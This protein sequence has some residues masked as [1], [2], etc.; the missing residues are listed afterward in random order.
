MIQSSSLALNSTFSLN[1]FERNFYFENH[2]D[3]FEDLGAISGIDS[4]IDARSFGVG[5]LDRDGDLDLVVK[6]LQRRLLQCFINEIETEAH[7]AFFSLTGSKSNR[8]AIGARIEIRHGRRSQMAQVRSASGFQ[9]QSSPEVF[10]GLGVDRQ[11]DHV[12]VYWP[13]G[14][15]QAFE[16]LA[17]GNVFHIHED[18]GVERSVPI[19]E[20][21][22]ATKLTSDSRAPVPKQTLF[23]KR[24]KAPPLDDV[25]T[26]GKAV[27]SD[28]LY[29][30]AVLA[31]FVQTWLP[32]FD[33]HLDLLEKIAKSHPDLEI[34]VFPHRG[35]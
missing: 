10:F 21:K 35:R 15:Q 9:S 11:I 26:N 22:S 6:N 17:A 30:G 31:S 25:D 4:D 23:A 33:A 14:K 2:G 24:R 29:Q 18:K 3:H 5:D 20:S 19:Q 27:K 1:G 13:S 28:S 12:T 16:N 7:R 32:F 34:L 8:D